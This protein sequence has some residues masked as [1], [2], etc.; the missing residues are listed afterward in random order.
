M[1]S[2]TLYG[3]YR[4]PCSAKLRIALDLKAIEYK[5][6]YV[7]LNKAEHLRDDYG[8]KNPSRSVPTLLVDETWGITQS[9]AALEDLEEA[10]PR[11]TPLLPTDTKS[12]A[13]VRTLAEIIA[14]DTQPLTN[15]TPLKRAEE[16]GADSKQWAQAFTKRGLDAFEKVASVTAGRYS[17]GDD[18]T[19]A[20]KFEVSL[21]PYPTSCRVY[22]ELREH[23][24]F[25]RSHW[26]QQPDCPAELR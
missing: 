10:Y 2:L 12:R 5:A 25:I 19:L 14:I 20:D 24:S 16:S 11:S 7:N 6:I 9:M 4:S 13:N 15:D 3:Y 21:E 23:V 17:C 1:S 22:A 8:S 26:Q 18:I